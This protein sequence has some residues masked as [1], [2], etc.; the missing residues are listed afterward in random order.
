MSGCSASDDFDLA[1]L[2]A[3]AAQLDLVVQAP[4]ELQLAVGAPPALVAGAIQARARLRR[5]R[6]GDEPLCRQV[7]TAQI[8]VGQARA[9]DVELTGHADRHRLAAGVEHVDLGVGEGPADRDRREIRGQLRRDAIAGGERRALGGPVAVD[10][11]HVRA[12]HLLRSADVP[13]RQRLAAGEDLA[14]PG[15]RL[16]TVVDQSD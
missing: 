8:A 5:E 15:Q 2:D 7:G 11:L 14:D 12:Q 10:Q 3:K 1:E 4:E 9:A 16:G 6:V 13:D